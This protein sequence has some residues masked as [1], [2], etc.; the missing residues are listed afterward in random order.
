MYLFSFVGAIEVLFKVANV[1]FVEIFQSQSSRGMC[2]C[3]VLNFQMHHFASVVFG[4]VD[5]FDHFVAAMPIEG[6]SHPLYGT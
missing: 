3:F 2:V 1:I 6:V 4:F 5:V